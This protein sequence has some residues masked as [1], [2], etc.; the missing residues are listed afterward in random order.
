MVHVS[1]LKNLSERGNMDCEPG[2][3]ADDAVD[4]DVLLALVEPAFLAAEPA[5]GLGRRWRQVQERDETNAACEQT[6]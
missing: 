4:H 1:R 5:P 6:F 2:I 3:V